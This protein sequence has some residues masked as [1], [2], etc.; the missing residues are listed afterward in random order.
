MQFLPFQ[1][2][3]SSVMCPQEMWMKK[4]NEEIPLICYF[5]RPWSSTWPCGCSYCL[6]AKKHLALEKWPTSL[7]KGSY[8][9]DQ[10]PFSTDLCL[11][12]GFPR[13]A[14]Q[15][16]CLLPVSMHGPGALSAAVWWDF[17][18]GGWSEGY[19]T[20]CLL[21]VCLMGLQDIPGCFPFR[22]NFALFLLWGII[23][24][25]TQ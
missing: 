8:T 1:M 20:V 21:F 14:P 11:M 22:E 9:W 25:L 10:F 17:S 16:C 6:P 15:C 4:W 2:F 23:E 7:G 12:L 18:G 13:P 24:I 3:V 5:L 19:S